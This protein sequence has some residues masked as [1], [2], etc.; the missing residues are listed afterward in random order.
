MVCFV[1]VPVGELAHHVPCW[2][3]GWKQTAGSSLLQALTEKHKK[4]VRSCDIYVI[5]KSTTKLQNASE[6][7]RPRQAPPGQGCSWAA[8][9]SSATG[10]LRS[11]TGQQQLVRKHEVDRQRRRT[12]L[13]KHG[14]R[15]VRWLAAYWTEAQ[16]RMPGEEEGRRA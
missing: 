9:G 4:L 16:Q 11:K 15:L 1:R 6:R 3:I 12:E 14:R 13:K 5:M 2:H 8:G 7:D 10:F